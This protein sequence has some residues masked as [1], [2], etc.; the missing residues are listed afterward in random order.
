M[1]GRAVCGV[2]TTGDVIER[3]APYLKRWCAGRKW[4]EA[5]RALTQSG[6]RIDKVTEP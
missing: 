5:R 4:I 3:F 2:V 6:G 1:I